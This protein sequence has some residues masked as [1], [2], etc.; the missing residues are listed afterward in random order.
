MLVQ[1]VAGLPPDPFQVSDISANEL[2]KDPALLIDEAATFPITGGSKVVRLTEVTDQDSETLKAFLT[3]GL[4]NVL[5]LAEAGELR[6]KSVLKRL[7]EEAD[8]AASIACYQDMA[9]TIRRLIQDFCQQNHLEVAPRA[10]DYLVQH[11]GSDRM[12][13]RRELEKLVTYMGEDNSISEADA[14][15][16]VGDNAVHSLNSFAVALADGSDGYMTR[17]WTS[18]QLQGT[19]AIQALRATLRHFQRLHY[20]VT[21]AALGQPSNISMKNLRPP[22]HFSVR[23]AFQR[24]VGIWSA[25]KLGHAM[26]ILTEAETHCKKKGAAGEV[27]TNMAFL[28]IINAAKKLNR[29]AAQHHH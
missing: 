20:V 22:I 18:L 2:R 11:L 19:T 10:L 24:Q 5:L 23:E 25:D 9:K 13:T 15:A 4:D 8:V 1:A 17:R 21:S 27:A 3:A 29:D 16:I 7:F 26:L 6:S 12:V 28:R 14:M